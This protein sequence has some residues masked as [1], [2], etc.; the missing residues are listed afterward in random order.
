MN[1]VTTLRAVADNVIQ[2]WNISGNTL[3]N[4]PNQPCVE[5]AMR[6]LLSPLVPDTAVTV[7]VKCGSPFP[8]SGHGVDFDFGKD[9]GDFFYGKFV[10]CEKL[11]IRHSTSPLG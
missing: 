6:L 4:W 1:W 9:S 2:T 8:A 11:G 10:N 7:G 5:K 3:R